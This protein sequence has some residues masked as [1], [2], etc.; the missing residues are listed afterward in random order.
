MRLPG[1]TDLAGAV[2]EFAAATGALVG[3][4]G[5]LVTLLPQV[6]LAM[7]R[8]VDVAD[9]AGVVIDRIAALAEEATGTLAAVD[10]TV[11]GV[12]E[13]LGRVALSV[14][15]I[16][17]MA[18][19]AGRTTTRVDDAVAP[20]A[21]LQP[22]FAAA[23]E[24]DLGQLRAVLLQL[25]ELVGALSHVG[26][27]VRSLRARVDDLHHLAIGLPGGRRLLRKATTED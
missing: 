6:E 8:L 17:A 20:L 1:P 19:K 14:T 2:R 18:R 9:Q 15:G 10:A 23:G 24:L 16:D 22:T 4:V 13:L 21:A 3:A 25:P 26:P 7:A 27:D 11:V 12:D 5:Q